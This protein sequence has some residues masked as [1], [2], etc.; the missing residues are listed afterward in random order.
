MSFTKAF[1]FELALLISFLDPSDC[2]QEDFLRELPRELLQRFWH[3][4]GAHGRMTWAPAGTTIHGNYI[5]KYDLIVFFYVY[6]D[7]VYLRF[8]CGQGEPLRGR[9]CTDG[10]TTGKQEDATYD[11]LT[12]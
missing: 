1:S 10:R 3:G 7:Y 9:A 12:R 2:L 4:S 11:T 6:R 5:S 8:M